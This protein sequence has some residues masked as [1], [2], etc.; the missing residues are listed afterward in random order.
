ML[1]ALAKTMLEA[2][3][4]D[5]LDAY[6]NKRLESIRNILW[7]TKKTFYLSMQSEEENIKNCWRPIEEMLE[8]RLWVAGGTT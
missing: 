1:E 7:G 6:Q 2:Y 3:Q 4:P 5:T 8:A